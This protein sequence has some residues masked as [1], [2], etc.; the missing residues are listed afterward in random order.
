MIVGDNARE[1]DMDVNITKEKKQTNMR[2]SSADEAIRLIPHRELSLEQAIE[3]IADDE[4]VGGHAEI[5][6]A[7]QRKCSTSR[8]AR[9]AGSRFA[10]APKPQFELALIRLE[11][12]S[13]SFCWSGRSQCRL[14]N[15]ERFRRF[16]RND[17]PLW[18]AAVMLRSF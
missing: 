1:A 12:S 16:A 17:R 5:A 8:S 15:E 18:V 7:A 13:E 10:P 2:A 4:Y 11:R 6:A 9:A 14:R 3:Y